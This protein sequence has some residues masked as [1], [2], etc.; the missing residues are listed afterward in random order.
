MGPR[1]PR[2]H[3]GED[4]VRRLDGG[5]GDVH[6]RAERAVTVAVGRGELQ[7]RDVDRAAPRAKELGDLGEK[8]GD[9]VD[10]PA[11]DLGA[12]VRPDEEVGHAEA[13]GEVLVGIA[14]GAGRV[15]VHDLHVAEA[16]VLLDE[17]VEEEVGGGDASVNEEALAGLNEGDGVAR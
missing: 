7:Q 14:R 3:L 10:A 5:D 1:H 15:E 17:G 16:R 11:I 6:A 9:V 2:V 13:P 8:A 12:H 4:H